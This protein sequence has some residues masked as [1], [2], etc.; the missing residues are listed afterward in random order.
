MVAVGKKHTKQASCTA[1][2]GGFV[3]KAHTPFQW[4]G[5]NGV[6]EMR[7][8]VSML[9][10]ATKR[11]GVQLRWHDPEASFAEGIV[12]RGDRRVGRGD[13][14]RVA[15]RRHVPGVERA[16]RA[17]PMARGMAAAGLDP[18][19][20]VTR[21]RDEHEILP[22]D[23]VAAGPAPRLPLAGLEGGARRARPPRLPLDPVLRLRGVHR[24]RDRARRGLGRRAG[25][26]EPGHRPGPQRRRR[27]PGARSCR[28]RRP[29]RP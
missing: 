23:H 22:W 8:K 3:P 21:H 26:W 7:R 16:L 14:A 4:F 5:Q 12:S 18:D 19:W 29:R 15:P 1:S 6:D 13:R 17:R 25:G 20:Y 27:G 24:L 2:V 28:P 11:T 9:R 10:D